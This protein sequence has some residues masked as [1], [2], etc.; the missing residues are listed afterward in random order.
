MAKS[1]RWHWLTK[2]GTIWREWW[3]G[4]GRHSHRC[5]EGIRSVGRGTAN[6]NTHGNHL[7]EDPSQVGASCPE[8][9]GKADHQ[10][11]EASSQEEG[12]Q[13][14]EGKADGLRKVV[15]GCVV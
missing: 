8:A 2:S 12:N 13:D 14:Q 4:R 15:R 3:E 10:G 6:L 5:S 9:E 1:R 7:E 11:Q